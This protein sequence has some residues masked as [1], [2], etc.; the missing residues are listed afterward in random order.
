MAAMTFNSTLHPLL[1]IPVLGQKEFFV[2]AYNA[3]VSACED[4]VV[5]VAG[6]SHYIKRIILN[7]EGL[8]GDPTVTIGSGETASAV[9]SALVG[10]LSVAKEIVT[11]T[12]ANEEHFAPSRTFIF[13]F[14]QG[15][16]KG[17]KLTKGE[18]LT[19]DSSTAIP[20]NIMVEGITV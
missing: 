19:I 8:T 6:K 2:D 12:P 20:V 13:D 7:V 4:V 17:R 11:G 10:P 14:A 9:T 15:R 1:E 16:N 18:A 3:D 5:A